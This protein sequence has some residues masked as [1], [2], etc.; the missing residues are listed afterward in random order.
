MKK[1]GA[2]DLPGSELG[3]MQSLISLHSDRAI[4]MATGPD[5]GVVVNDSLSLNMHKRG[6]V[7]MMSDDGM[8]ADLD[9]NSAVLQLR[10][11]ADLGRMGNDAAA[12]GRIE[13]IYQAREHGDVPASVAYSIPCQSVH[14]HLSRVQ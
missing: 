11:L 1:D 10:A 9:A 13:S 8:R 5:R 3:Q 14:D 6:N 2:Q 12:Q 4:E 7:H